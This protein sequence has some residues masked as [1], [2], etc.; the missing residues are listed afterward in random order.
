[1]WELNKSKI[2]DK[3]NTNKFEINSTFFSGIY[4]VEEK[5]ENE[6]IRKHQYVRDQHGRTY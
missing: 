4:S 3:L 2:N 1:M 5:S 6:F